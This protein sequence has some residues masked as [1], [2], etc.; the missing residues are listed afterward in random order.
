MQV[1]VFSLSQRAADAS[2]CFGTAA[3][4]N[5]AVSFGTTIAPRLTHSAMLA[6]IAPTVKQLLED[7][8]TWVQSDVAERLR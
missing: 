4:A 3:R 8:W 6:T 1:V 2:A 7:L 5:A